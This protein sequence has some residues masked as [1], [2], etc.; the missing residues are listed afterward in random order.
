MNCV[1]DMLQEPADMPTYGSSFHLP[2]FSEVWMVK[3]SLGLLVLSRRLLWCIV[4]FY[5]LNP[6]S[7]K[8][9]GAQ[10]ATTVHG[11]D[12]PMSV[13]LKSFTKRNAQTRKH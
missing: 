4:I 6:C 8:C 11:S 13:F 9:Y 12:S 10:P 3:C 7:S 5:Q 2:C 1:G